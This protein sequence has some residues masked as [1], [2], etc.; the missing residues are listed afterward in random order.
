MS[1]Q[2]TVKFSALLIAGFLSSITG[3]SADDRFDPLPDGVIAAE[4]IS[5]LAKYGDLLLIGG[6]EA[7]KISKKRGKNVIQ[8]LRRGATGGLELEGKPLKLFTGHKTDDG[9]TEMD[10]EGIAVED[11]TVIIVG[12]HSAKRPRLKKKKD[13]DENLLQL[14]AAAILPEPNR[15]RIYRLKLGT[16]GKVKS[17]EYISLSSL[18]AKHP[19]LGP[20][21]PLPS[22]ENGIDIEGVA[23]AEEMLYLGFRGPV[24]R[25][26]YVPVMILDFGD[27]DN[28]DL[29]Y[30]R[31]GGRGIRDITRVE[32]GFLII[33]G[34]VGD[35]PVSYQ[36]FHWDG[37]DMVPGK[38]RD[39][40]KLGKILELAEIEPPTGGKAEGVTV[41]SE[42]EDTYQLLLA[43]DGVKDSGKV[44]QHRSV[45][46]DGSSFSPACL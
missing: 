6:D 12:S 26:G 21:V 14:D 2:R 29:V 43:Y 19:V 15:G 9:G 10:I 16:N 46:K 33:G 3:V 23:V 45:S 41:M 44:L 4:D 40:Q 35:S 30:V 8:I 34:P 1:K 38:G 28:S 24:L 32:D 27:P 7:D 25:D 31:L 37:N 39:G 17:R 20:Y 11:N 5:G 13:Y 42:S 36:L 22:K 18:L